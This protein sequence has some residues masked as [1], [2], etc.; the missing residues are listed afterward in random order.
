MSEFG[1]PISFPESFLGITQINF[2]QT[3]GSIVL[4]YDFVPVP[5]PSS[6]A[7]MLSALVCLWGVLL[8]DRQRVPVRP[9]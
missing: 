3:R 4:T 9:A 8:I 7:L 2:G 5:E 1:T 6:L